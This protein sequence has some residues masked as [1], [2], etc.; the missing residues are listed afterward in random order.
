V[1]PQTN[2]S[3][4][5]TDL[6][7][8]T[9]Q[10]KD[11]YEKFE[12]EYCFYEV[13]YKFALQ[14]FLKK[15]TS[16]DSSQ[17]AEANSM[18]DITISLNRKLNYL[19]EMMNYISSQRVTDTNSHTLAINTMKDQIEANRV[20]LQSV[21]NKLMGANG[22]LTV[23]TVQKEMVNYTQEKNNAVTNQI[24]VWAALNVLA[25]ATIFYVYRMA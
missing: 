9:N 8:L 17:N 10:D 21:Y 1:N 7:A 23:L 6:V 11:L 25:L 12:E 5:V 2:V 15:A 20:G 3:E 22:D 24:S 4:T 16:R 13:R 18:L 19:I 14:D